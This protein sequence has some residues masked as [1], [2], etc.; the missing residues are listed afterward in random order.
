MNKK[1]LA[2]LA[3]SV[4]TSGCGITTQAPS[5]ICQPLTF[6]CHAGLKKHYLK[7]KVGLNTV[8]ALMYIS[9]GQNEKAITLL[10]SIETSDAYEQAT[11]QR[12]LAAAYLQEEQFSQALNSIQQSLSSAKI[13]A[14]EFRDSSLLELEILFR[15][16]DYNDIRVKAAQ[17]LAYTE[18]RQDSKL[19]SLLSL[20]AEQQ[21]S[22]DLL[23]EIYNGY[24]DLSPDEAF[25]SYLQ[26]S[27]SK[28]F[29]ASTSSGQKPRVKV[30][31]EPK[32]PL[33]AIKKRIDKGQVT[34]TFDLN[35]EGKP[36]NIKVVESNPK[37]IFDKSGI[38]ALENWRYFVSLD[39]NN[40]VVGGKGIEVTLEWLLL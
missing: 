28:K 11:I 23:K 12:L 22:D 5:E 2:T 39:G 27:P 21:Q 31:M 4:M 26:K 35:S 29:V 37:K 34:Y 30:R 32:Y 14:N 1:L 40:E 9:E 7:E 36:T 10:S 3:L 13:N 8:E 19:F 16:G 6:Q 24:S 17:Y 25:T 20:V 33:N 38:E 18:Q 15:L